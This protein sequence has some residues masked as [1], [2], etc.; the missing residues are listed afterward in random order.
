MWRPAPR[1]LSNPAYLRR[2]HRFGHRYRR[3]QLAAVY[4]AIPGPDG[5]ETRPTPANADSS[6]GKPFGNG[7]RHIAIGEASAHRDAT[8]WNFRL[9]QMRVGQVRWLLRPIRQRFQRPEPSMPRWRHAER[10]HARS[11]PWHGT[12]PRYRIDQCAFPK[13]CLRN[14]PSEKK[15]RLH[16]RCHRADRRRPGRRRDGARRYRRTELRWRQFN[17][18]PGRL[19][20]LDW[21]CRRCRFG[22]ATAACRRLNRRWRC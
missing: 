4:G 8:D 6:P 21:S 20:A 13:A 18:P 3:S 2:D 12:K 17:P 19:V 16:L 22:G 1:R 11:Q 10:G 9:P 7:Q 14:A 15:V 5:H